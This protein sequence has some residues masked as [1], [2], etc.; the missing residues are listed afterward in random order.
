MALQQLPRIERLD[1]AVL[2]LPAWH[3]EAAGS[4]TAPVYGYVI[5]HPD[6]AIVFDTGVGADN[7]FIDAVYAPDH[8]GL[9]DALHAVGIELA[10]VV[11]VVNSHL[12]FDHCGQNP[13]FYGSDVPCYVQQAELDAVE[14]DQ[15][16]TDPVWALAPTGQQRAVDGDLAIAEGVTIMATP[17]H[18]AGHH[19]VL[20]E[21]GE[22]CAVLAGQVVWHADEFRDERATAANVEAK[23]RRGDAIESIRRLK[24]LRPQVVHFAHCSA[25][26]ADGAGEDAELRLRS[27]R[28]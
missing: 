7:E 23:E 9:D 14:R 20:V 28:G 4:P 13:L 12:H 10:D 26:H 3:P 15:F 19:S 11:A 8:L 5:D 17:G 18:T 22:G 25:L 2:R 6:G 21:S 1:L 27:P 24:A 16:Y